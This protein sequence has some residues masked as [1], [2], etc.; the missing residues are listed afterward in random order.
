MTNNMAG[1]LMIS[2]SIW[3]T[4]TEKEIPILVSIGRSKTMT[5]PEIFSEVE[6]FFLDTPSSRELILQLSDQQKKILKPFGVKS[7]VLAFDLEELTGAAK[8][9]LLGR[10]VLQYKKEII[11]IERGTLVNPEYLEKQGTELTVAEE[12]PLS[13]DTSE[14]T[15]SR[16]N[17]SL[18]SLSVTS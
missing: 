2:Y 8:W 16:V 12:L 15:I 7:R 11:Q 1:E 18:E 14:D 5:P 9:K 4:D 3:V 17:A 10:K 6:Y 13:N